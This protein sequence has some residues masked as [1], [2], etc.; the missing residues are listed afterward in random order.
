MRMGP[1]YHQFVNNKYS[2]NVH[3]FYNILYVIKYYFLDV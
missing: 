2:R 3:N 1:T